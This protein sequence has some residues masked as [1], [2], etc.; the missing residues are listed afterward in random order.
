MLTCEDLPTKT[1]LPYTA[2]VE[3]AEKHYF[4]VAVVASEALLSATSSVSV[5]HTSFLFC[6]LDGVQPFNDGRGE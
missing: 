1:P 3:T 2:T 6:P 5:V 4:A